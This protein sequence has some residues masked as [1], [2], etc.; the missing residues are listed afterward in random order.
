MWVVIFISAFLASASTVVDYCTIDRNRCDDDGIYKYTWLSS[1]Q[2][3]LIQNILDRDVETIQTDI[4]MAK[5]MANNTLGLYPNSPRA[6]LNMLTVKRYLMKTIEVSLDKRDSYR[7]QCIS[8]CKTIL[9]MPS[10]ILPSLLYLVVC[11]L[12][13]FLAMETED[14]QISLDATIVCLQNP[15]NLDLLSQKEFRIHEITIFFMM[16]NFEA[17]LNSMKQYRADMRLW[18]SISGKPAPDIPMY[19][20]A[21]ET[22]T[23]RILG[24]ISVDEGLKE[25]QK[26]PH[27]SNKDIFEQKRKFTKFI[28]L[29]RE[30]TLEKDV[31]GVLVNIAETP[32]FFERAVEQNL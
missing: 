10:I 18:S 12:Y 22:A 5:D 27:G 6:V 11:K 9:A 8:L 31:I 15:N 19:I 29:C 3:F 24:K 23:K 32:G 21:L 2:D 30:K 1:Y 26:N 17:S 7:A 25:I 14:T 16:K 13:V 20:L 4:E 28:D